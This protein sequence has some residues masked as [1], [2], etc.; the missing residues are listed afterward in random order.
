MEA[1]SVS[2]FMRI[3]PRKVRVLLDVIRRQRALDALDRL[4]TM[5]QK[6]AKIV[7]NT[8][9]SA[10]ANA[11]VKK[12]DETQLYVRVAKADDGPRMKRFL[13]RSMGRADRIL[14]RMSHVTVVVADKADF[15]GVVSRKKETSAPQVRSVAKTKKVAKKVQVKKVKTKKKSGDK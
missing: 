9:K 10:I 12:M 3:G 7:H 1:R 6:G 14:K 2:K 5:P 15:I 4:S 13:P 8:L 11:K